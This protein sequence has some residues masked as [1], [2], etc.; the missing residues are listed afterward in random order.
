VVIVG[1]PAVAVAVIVLRDD[2]EP[3]PPVVGSWA[4]VDGDGSYQSFEVKPGNHPDSYGSI[5][6]TTPRLSAVV[7]P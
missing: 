3:P 2:P 5:F 1:G 4:G 7:P 6:E